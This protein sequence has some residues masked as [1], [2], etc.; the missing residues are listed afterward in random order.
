LLDE[1]ALQHAQTELK[2]ALLDE[3]EPHQ[4]KGASLVIVLAASLLVVCHS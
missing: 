4:P 1:D 3:V 2:L